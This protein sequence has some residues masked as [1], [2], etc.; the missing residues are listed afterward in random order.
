GIPYA[1]P[2]VGELRWQPPQPV[3]PW[4]GVKVTRRYG[5]EVRDRC[6]SS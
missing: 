2:P 1:R 6:I 5:P 3:E 4:E